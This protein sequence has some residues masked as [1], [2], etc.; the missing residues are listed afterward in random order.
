MYDE[1]RRRLG[2]GQRV[3]CLMKDLSKVQN[4]TLEQHTIGFRTIF[5]GAFVHKS[6][7]DARFPDTKWGGQLPKTT[8]RDHLIQLSTVLKPP[9]PPP[10]ATKN[11]TT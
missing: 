9:P 8:I 2:N 3:W 6:H 1:E 5:L 7:I 4:N 10:P 11:I